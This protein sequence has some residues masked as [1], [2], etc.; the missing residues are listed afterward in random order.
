MS[1]SC[2]KT[3]LILP[4]IVVAIVTW[5]F[6]FLVHGV[7]LKDVYA[8]TAALWRPEEEMQQFWWACIAYHL[9]MAAIFTKGFYWWRPSVTCGACFTK[10]CPVGKAALGYGLWA[11]LFMAVPQLMVYVWMPVP[12]ELTVYWALSELAK[13]IVATIPLSLIYLKQQKA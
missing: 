2:C 5:A 3:K 13:Y 7:L 10:E 8:A 1:E 11:G 6:D 12:Q 9:V 4:I